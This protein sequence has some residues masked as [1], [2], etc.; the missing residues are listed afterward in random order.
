MFA[1]FS[2]SLVETYEAPKTPEFEK[3]GDD[4]YPV[5]PSA[6]YRHGARRLTEEQLTDLAESV[7]D[8]IIDRGH[9]FES[10]E[11]FLSP[12]T[13]RRKKPLGQGDRDSHGTEWKTRVVSRLGT[14]RRRIRI[15]EHQLRSTIS[16]QVF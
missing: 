15:D 12:N 10:M 11:A 2:H 8:Q 3:T 7:V 16:R 9:P 5:A 6:F 1:R 4:V 14:G 13:L